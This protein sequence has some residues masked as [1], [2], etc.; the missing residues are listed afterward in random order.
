VHIYVKEHRTNQKIARAN[1]IQNQQMF[2]T[3]LPFL[4]RPSQPS[5]L[6]ST[7]DSC[8]AGLPVFRPLYF[9][10]AATARSLVACRLLLMMGWPMAVLVGV[11]LAG[12]VLVQVLGKTL[13][14]QKG[15]RAGMP[16]AVGANLVSEWLV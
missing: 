9:W 6:Q 8:L 4:V 15:V 1:I 7:P 5:S 11:V 13:T 2:L 3:V 10:L 14:M 16:T 12:V